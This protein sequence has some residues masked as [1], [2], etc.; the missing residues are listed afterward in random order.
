MFMFMYQRTDLAI[1]K[2]FLPKLLGKNLDHKLLPFQEGRKNDH[3]IDPQESPI[4]STYL[5]AFVISRFTYKES[6]TLSNG[7]QFRIWYRFYEP[8]FR[9]KKLSDNI[10]KMSFKSCKNL[11]CLFWIMISDLKGLH[12]RP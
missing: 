11:I 4:M 7:V 3:N 6:E 8:S 5:L 1:L 9:T 2:I 12:K 10:F